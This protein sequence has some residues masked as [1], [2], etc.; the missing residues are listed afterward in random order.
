MSVWDNPRILFRT[1]GN[2]YIWS[3]VVNPFGQVVIQVSDDKQTSASIYIRSRIAEVRLFLP[4]EKAGDRFQR[5]FRG[6]V[7][8]AFRVGF[9]SLGGN[10]DGKQ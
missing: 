5:H 10:T 4:A 3:T 6:M 2:P 8:H 1:L 7:L 9:G